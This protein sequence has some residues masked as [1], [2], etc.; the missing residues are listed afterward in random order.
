M[1]DLQDHNLEAEILWWIDHDLE[2]TEEVE[3]Q[4]SESTQHVLDNLYLYTQIC[5]SSILLDVM[6]ILSIQ[7]LPTIWKKESS[8][9]IFPK[10]EQNIPKPDALLRLFGPK[11]LPTKLKRPNG[12]SKSKNW[13][14][15]TKK[16]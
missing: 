14:E 2:E 3:D 7:A 4:Q 5:D 13:K 12:N 15:E 1:D 11:K 10:L 6:M 8:I 9:I 16:N